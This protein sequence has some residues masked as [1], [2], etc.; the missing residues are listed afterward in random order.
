ME[1]TEVNSQGV[2]KKTIHSFGTTPTGDELQGLLAQGRKARSD[3]LFG[4]QEKEEAAPA[5]KQ[6][7]KM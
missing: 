6:K 4:K 7:M 1:N 2:E 5:E 3:Y